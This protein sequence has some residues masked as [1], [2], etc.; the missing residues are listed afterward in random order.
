MLWL[1]AADGYFEQNRL[2]S[3]PVQLTQHRTGLTVNVHWRAAF[4]IL[5]KFELI[6]SVNGSLNEAANDDG[7]LALVRDVRLFHVE[8]E[9]QVSVRRH[10]AKASPSGSAITRLE[11]CDYTGNDLHQ[12]R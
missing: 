8:P 11:G 7:S 6:A 3:T 9:R 10:E 5:D 4:L 12:P 2:G 1:D